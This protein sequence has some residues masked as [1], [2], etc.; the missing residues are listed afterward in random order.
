MNKSMGYILIALYAVAVI[1]FGILEGSM[2]IPAIAEIL[3][4]V[5][6]GIG[7]GFILPVLHSKTRLFPRFALY[8]AAIT[9]VCVVVDVA[10]SNTTALRF[11]ENA[12]MFVSS[13]LGWFLWNKAG[14]PSR[15]E[16]DIDA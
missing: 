8:A 1:L 16:L 15:K 3:L 4:W 10:H 5:I 12:A 11:T 7:F 2:Q 6:I 13:M 14:C 9:V